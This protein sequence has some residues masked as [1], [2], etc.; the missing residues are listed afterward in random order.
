[1]KT[2]WAISSALWCLAFAA[3]QSQGSSDEDWHRCQSDDECHAYCAGPAG[4]PPVG[5]CVTDLQPYKVCD[6]FVRPR[7][8]PAEAAKAFKLTIV[9]A[10]KCRSDDECYPICNEKQYAD[11]PA[12]DKAFRQN[13]DERTCLTTGTGGDT[14]YTYHGCFCQINTQQSCDRAC[15]QGNGYPTKGLLANGECNCPVSD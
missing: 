6:C 1:M 10:A 4:T 9:F 2:V 7:R 14:A 12:F 15:S 3:A 5:H 13:V 11:E 8:N